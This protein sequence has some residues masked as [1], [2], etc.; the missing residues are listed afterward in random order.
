MKNNKGFTLIEILAVIIIL[1]VI[2]IIA[3]PAISQ[4]ILDSRKSSYVTSVQKYIDAA[5]EEVSSYNYRVNNENAAY[6][7]PTKCLQTENGDVSPF[8][9]MLES[10]VV[11]TYDKS[12][13]Y[14]Y[15]YI[16][17]DTSN[18]GFE[19]TKSEDISTDK[20]K[21]D[22]KVVNTNQKVGGRDLIIVYSDSCDKTTTRSGTETSILCGRTIGESTG[23]TTEDRTITIDCQGNCAQPSYTQ[24]FTTTT[25]EGY[26]SIYDTS[27]NKKD[28]LVNVY[29]DKETP[30]IT[31]NNV[32]ISGTKV[33]FNL[34]ATYA[35]GH[36]KGPS[37]NI[38][39]YC[40]DTNNLC[41]PNTTAEDG[42]KVIAEAPG[43]EFYIRYQLTTGAGYTTKIKNYKH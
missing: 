1:G 21:D 19:L 2:M 39:K 15:Y 34:K 11:V 20:L 32:S 35:P 29:V 13:R 41:F 40:I 24:T 6:Y 36:S 4:N 31:I 18:H 43:G 37:G 27:S 26:I 12:G 38:L 16:G 30:D 28:C 3:I 25:Q 14:D 22:I 9:D 8:G 33:E 5:R 23:W 42:K 17:R 10:Y 7:I